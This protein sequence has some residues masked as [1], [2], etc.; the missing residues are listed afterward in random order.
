MVE[1]E[2]VDLAFKLY[3]SVYSSYLKNAS[4]KTGVIPAEIIELFD[5]VTDKRK[6]RIL[7]SSDR[8]T[9]DDLTYIFGRDMAGR[10]KYLAQLEYCLVKRQGSFFVP[11]EEE[12]CDLITEYI[13][14]NIN[15]KK[16][17]V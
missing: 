17:V 3:V 4:V 6:L 13:N 1:K 2:H 12:F 8:W 11:L 5:G 9:N 10:F 14:V 16:E 7:S 15:K